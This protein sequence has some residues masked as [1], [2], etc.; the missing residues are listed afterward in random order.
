MRPSLMGTGMMGK[1]MAR[2][3]L[4]ACRVAVRVR[5]GRFGS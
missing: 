1:R 2:R 4:D 3:L 5:R